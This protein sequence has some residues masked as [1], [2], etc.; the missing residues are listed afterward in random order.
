MDQQE[1]IARCSERLHAQWPTVPADQLVEV[2]AEI[3][4]RVQRQL[5]D[6]HCAAVEWLRQG[7]PVGARSDAG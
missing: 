7:M 3:Q 2:A 1:W 5:D 4:S 6:P